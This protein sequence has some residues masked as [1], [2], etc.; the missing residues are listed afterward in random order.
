MIAVMADAIEA[1]SHEVFITYLAIPMMFTDDEIATKIRS[2]YANAPSQDRLE[3]ARVLAA[4]KGPG[5]ITGP[6][7]S[8]V[9]E[10]NGLPPLPGD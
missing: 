1:M 5:G 9:R 7:R 10:I 3:L 8:A 6:I 2:Y 4:L